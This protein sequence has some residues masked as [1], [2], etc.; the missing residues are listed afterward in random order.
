[1]RRF[2]RRSRPRS[3]PGAAYA[4]AASA[5]AGTPWREASFAVVDLEMT[6]LDPEHDEIISFASVPI[7]DGR[8][9]AGR[10]RAAIVRP[11]RMPTATTIRIHGLRPADLAAA[12]PLAEV[13]DLVLEA[14]TGRILVAHP[15]WVERMFLAPALRTAGVKL[16]EPVLCT[17]RIAAHV[18]A[19]GEGSGEREI[20]LSEAA[21]RLNLPVHRPHEAAGDALTTAQL[22]LALATRLERRSP[23]TVGTLAKLS[24]G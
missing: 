21:E 24:G 17:A 2:F 18:L 4:R 16:R 8:V 3:A 22:F 12:P 11:Q 1:M 23:Q 15:A 19:S 10:T 14:L 6:G 5:S 13:L 7:D 20:P 9:L